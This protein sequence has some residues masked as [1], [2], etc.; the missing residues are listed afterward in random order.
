MTGYGRGEFS[1]GPRTATCEIRSVNHRYCEVTVKMPFK[2]GFAEDAVRQAVK[3]AAG[4][5]KADVSIS[6]VSTADEDTGVVLGEA[7]AKQYLGNL[8]T[9][10]EKYG[11]GGEIT[12]GLLA[13]LPDVLK[14]GHPDLDADAISFVIMGAV[15]AALEGF[16]VMREKEGASLAENIGGKLDAVDELCRKI[17]ARAPEVQVIYAERLRERIAS[18]SNLPGDDAVLQQRIAVEIAAFADKA[19][20]DEELVRLASHVGQFRGIL[21]SRETAPVGKKLDFIVQEMNREANTVGSKA[22][23]LQITDL[24]IELKNEIENIR[25]QIQNIC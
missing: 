25:E 4:R 21:A 3:A 20:I 9:L 12:V 6:L 14:Q 11:V 24:M 15:S 23:D 2:Y 13:G 7:A 16:G 22:N 8:R 10:Q 1:E 17:G 19:G 18:L 5:G